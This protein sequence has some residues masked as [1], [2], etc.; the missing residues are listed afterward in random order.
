[1]S[2]LTGVIVK[3]LAFLNDILDYFVTVAPLTVLGDASCGFEYTVYNAEMT[4]CGGAF[5]DNLM[6]LAY[7]LVELAPQLLE[8]LFAV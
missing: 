3:G 8:G 2:L 7:G 5:V 6:G 4:T 1:M